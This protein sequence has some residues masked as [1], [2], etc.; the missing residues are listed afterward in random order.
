MELEGLQRCKEKFCEY[1]VNISTLVTD[2]HV[3]VNKWIRSEWPSVTHY[4]DIWHVAK[5]LNKKMDELGKKRTVTSSID[6]HAVS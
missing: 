1:G 4:F 5:S 2:R 3:Q 6:G